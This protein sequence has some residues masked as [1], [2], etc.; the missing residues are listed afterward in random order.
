MVVKRWNTVVFGIA[1]VF[2]SVVMALS[3]S[4]VASTQAQAGRAAGQGRG[5][6]PSQDNPTAGPTMPAAQFQRMMGDLSN[7]NRWGKDD[8]KGAINLITDAKRKAATGLVKSGVSVSMSHSPLTEKTV[9]NPSPFELTML[10]RPGLSVGLDSWKISHHGYTFSHLDALCHYTFEGKMYNGYAASEVTTTGC[11]KD[12]VDQMREG[13]LTRGILIDIPR[14]K[15]VPYLEAPTAITKADVEAWLKKVNIKL[16][17][18]DAIFVRTGRWGKRA[19]VGPFSIQGN[20]AGLLISAGPLL[21]D[22]SLAGSDV[23]MDVAPSAVEGQGT[24]VHTFLLVALGVPIMDNADL[25]A[26]ADTAARLNR[27]EFMVS[28]NPIAVTG[29]TGGLVNA[30]ATF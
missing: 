12:G 4:T 29:G 24:P 16:T 18:G 8:Q 27:W 9:D 14:L 22:V 17:P 5:T 3:L 28:V 2:A 21:K 26:V 1:G 11:M 6:P 13:I 7:W 15:G 23:G 30:V 19:A 20:S 10:G 25:E